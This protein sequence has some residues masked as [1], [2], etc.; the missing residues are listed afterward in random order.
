MLCRI[1]RGHKIE[2]ILR[3][4]G[5][6]KQNKLQPVGVILGG[7]K[8]YGLKPIP[9]CRGGDRAA[10]QQEHHAQKQN[11]RWSEQRENSVIERTLTGLSKSGSGGVAEGAA[12]GEGTLRRGQNCQ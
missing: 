12:L 1:F 8:T 9:L 6:N 2:S 11:Q 4:H 7:N 3:G 5:G 10:V